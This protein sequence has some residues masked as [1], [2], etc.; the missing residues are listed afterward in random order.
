MPNVQKFVDR[1]RPRP[2]L[3]RRLVAALQECHGGAQDEREPPGQ[4]PCGR[5]GQ[6]AEGGRGGGVA[7][8]GLGGDGVDV[9]EANV[10]RVEAVGLVDLGEARVVGLDELNVD[11]LVLLVLF[12]S[13]WSPTG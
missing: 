11:A 7:A 12:A 3:C 8:D 6:G 2:H 10:G 9:G 5:G 4:P 1:P 13:T